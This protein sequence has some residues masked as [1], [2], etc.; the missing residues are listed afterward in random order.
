MARRQVCCSVLAWAKRWGIPALFAS[1]A[2]I[3]PALTLAQEIVPP[4]AEEY[5]LT[6]LPS[7]PGVPVSYGGMVFMPGNSNVLLVGG[8]ANG[9]EGALYAI[10]VIRD[11]G[12]HVVGFAGSASMAI[13][14][15]Y[16]N[17]G[18]T[19]H[20]S[21]VLFLA[22][23]PVNEIGQVRVGSSTT[24]K[25]VSLSSF[26]IVGSPG[27]LTFVPFGF[28]GFNELKM[29]TYSSGGW[30]TVHLVPDGGGLLDVTDVTYDGFVDSGADAFAY[31]PPGSPLF[32]DYRS[33]LVANWNAGT[34]TA[35]E[36]DDDGNPIWYTRSVFLTGL[37][38]AEGIVAD[39]V[40]GDFLVST[41]SL[42]FGYANK[43]VVIRG[44]PGPIGVEAWS[45]AEV[46]S[47]YR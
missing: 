18:V 34:V 3:S 6:V 29:I 9:P 32:V 12:D 19:Y 36:L 28:P 24:D 7:P 17:G 45:W 44:F 11:S 46:K 16:V 21:G 1:L 22:R 15:P 47:L 27:G 10:D 5:L 40:T 26:D 30:Y 31:V 23:Y 38:A 33:I 41:A 37:R 13:D 35:Y 8:E 25:V 43:I 4:Y 39:P 14:A 42:G 20:T 2:L